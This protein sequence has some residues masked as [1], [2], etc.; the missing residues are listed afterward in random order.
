MIIRKELKVIAEALKSLRD[1]KIIRSKNLVG[2]LGEYY[3]CNFFNLTINLNSVEKGFDAKDNANRKVEIKTRRTPE[4]KSK[5]IFRGFD[6]DYCLFVELDEYFEPLSILKINTTEIQKKL[7][8]KGDRL[9]V[10][11]IRATNHEIVYKK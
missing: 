10:S 1:D 3:C 7:D 4:G 2:D 6:F 8:N 9:S 5:I 11:R